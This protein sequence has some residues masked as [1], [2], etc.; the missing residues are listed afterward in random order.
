MRY[1]GFT[2]IELL[3]VI[4]IIGVLSAIVLASLNSSRDKGKDAAIKSSLD[5]ARKS[6]ALY[7]AE[8]GNTSMICTNSARN[9]YIGPFVQAA[10]IEYRGAASTYADATPS[11]W[12]TAQCHDTAQSDWVAWVPLR[13]STAAS[14]RGWCVDNQGAAKETTSVLAASAMTCP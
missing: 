6:A 5:A 14:P 12:D 11:T 9:H 7:Q 1:K 10:E 13:S 8:Y 4:A 3:V 2:L